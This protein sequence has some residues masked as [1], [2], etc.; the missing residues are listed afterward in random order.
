MLRR[1]LGRVFVTGLI[2][3]VL[4]P[5]TALFFLAFLPRF[6]SPSSGPASLQFMLLGLVFVA[7]AFCTDTSS[8][9]VAS[10]ARAW[11]WR[12]PSVVSS[13]RYLV[14]SAYVGLGLTATVSGNGRK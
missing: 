3:N 11:L 4:N 12:H 8:S 2:V 5:K 10:G 13:E 1:S 7:I 6:A 14:G 9:F